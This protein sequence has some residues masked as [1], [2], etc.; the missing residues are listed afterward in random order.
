MTSRHRMSGSCAQQRTEHLEDKETSLMNKTTV[1]DGHSVLILAGGAEAEFQC[2][3]PD[4][5]W[6]RRNVVG[7]GEEPPTDLNWCWYTVW[8]S[9]FEPWSIY[10]GPGGE[11]HSGPVVFTQHDDGVTWRYLSDRELELSK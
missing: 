9:G 2:H 11:P 10:D 7:P 6:C 3:E 4:T 1:H 5:A 8:A